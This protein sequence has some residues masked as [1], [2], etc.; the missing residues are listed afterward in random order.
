MPAPPEPDLEII[1]RAEVAYAEHMAAKSRHDEVIEARRR[2][3]ATA[4][5]A[6]V[7][8]LAI[9]GAAGDVDAIDQA[10]QARARAAEA[11]AVAIEVGDAMES[12]AAELRRAIETAKAD[13]HR[14]L[15]AYA[16]AEAIEAAK[17][18][19]AAI[20]AHG[21]AIGRYDRAAECA[22]RARAAGVVPP[23]DDGADIQLQH[24]Y[25]TS[26]IPPELRRILRPVAAERAI[27]GE[28]APKGDTP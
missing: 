4:E 22:N 28:Y 12:R 17:D 6:K 10:R 13:A 18:A 5:A 23:F 21:A 9:H 7:S 11:L 2:E 20:K 16:A 24:R 1:K 25:P 14:P 26:L 3:D 19:A 15:M 27:W 8:A